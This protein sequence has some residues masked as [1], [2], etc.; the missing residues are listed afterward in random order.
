VDRNEL[1]ALR[2]RE[3]M[4]AQRRAEFRASRRGQRDDSAREKQPPF[5]G[6]AP[7]TR[8]IERDEG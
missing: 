4:K 1:A 3:S 2:A 5:R 7:R 8:C 6:A